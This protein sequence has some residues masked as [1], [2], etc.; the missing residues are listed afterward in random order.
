M[1][2]RIGALAAERVVHFET[3]ALEAVAAAAGITTPLPMCPFPERV[4]RPLLVDASGLDRL[5]TARDAVAAARDDAVAAALD[6]L[7]SVFEDVA[8]RP[9]IRRDADSGGGRTIAYLDCMRGLDLT[10]GPNVLAELEARCRVSYTHRA[11][12]AGGSSSAPSNF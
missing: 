9:A 7:D 8:G 11:G 1:T 2:V 4:L 10:V 6:E 3:W 12:G 5:E